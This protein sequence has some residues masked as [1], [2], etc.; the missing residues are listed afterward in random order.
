MSEPTSFDPVKPTSSLDPEPK[1]DED[2]EGIYRYLPGDLHPVS[3]GELYNNKYLVLRKLG[4]GRY[5]T[6]WLVQDTSFVIPSATPIL[7]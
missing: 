2:K 7:H 6:V 3:L 4:Y 5:S 1:E